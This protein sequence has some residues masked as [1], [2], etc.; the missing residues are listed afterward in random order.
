MLNRSPRSG[1]AD[2]L[3]LAHGFTLAVLVG[4][5]D[6]GLAEARAETITAPGRTTHIVRMRITA[7][8]RRAIKG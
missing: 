6:D 1:C 7:A 3:L 5:V 8:G 2:T 4:L